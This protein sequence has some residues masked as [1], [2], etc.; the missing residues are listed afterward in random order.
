MPIARVCPSK[1]LGGL[2]HVLKFLAAAL[3][4]VF[5]GPALAADLPSRKAP[6]AA[7]PP[8]LLDWSGWYA[9]LNIGGAF[10]QSSTSISTSPGYVTSLNPFATEFGLLASAGPN[11]TLRGGKGGLIGGGQAGYNVQFGNLVAGLEADFQ[12][13]TAR[14]G[15]SAA[16]LGIDI[17]LEGVHTRVSGSTSLDWFGTFRGRLGMLATPSLLLYGTGGLALGGVK[18]SAVVSG[19]DSPAPLGWIPNLT[20][21]WGVSASRVGTKAGWALG[22]GGEWMFAQNWS[23]KAEYLYYNLG[24]A[25]NF[26]GL[27]S[28][29]TSV[30][31]PMFVAPTSVSARVD[32]HI[33]RAGLNYHFNLGGSGAAVAKY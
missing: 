7:P 4:F 23:A 20:D 6:L 25:T 28:N 19:A 22:A 15:G 31:G 13:S 2:M 5:A 12:G 21:V 14:S 32:G 16:T 1:L 17:L 30:W 11:A 18:S 24:R 8:G 33:V 9:G 26:V 27:L 3:G 10:G 29:G